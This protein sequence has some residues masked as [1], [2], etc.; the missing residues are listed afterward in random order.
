M[1]DDK[2]KKGEAKLVAAIKRLI[3]SMPGDD[4]DERL[5]YFFGF[6]SAAAGLGSMRSM[7]AFVRFVEKMEG[8]H[9]QVAVR[10]GERLWHYYYSND[11]RR[12]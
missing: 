6:V 9:A 8:K 12:S 2:R 5:T 3:D 7:Q 10:R 1:S 4:D 11:Y